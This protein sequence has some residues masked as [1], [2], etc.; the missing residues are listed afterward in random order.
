MNV[1][2]VQL[3]NVY[4]DGITGFKGT[5][6]GKCEYLSGCNQVLLVPKVDKD[7]KRLAGEWFDIQRLVLVP[8]EPVKL[9]NS[10]TP[11]CDMP[12]PQE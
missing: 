3:G 6:T 12:A 7:G 1:Q 2:E 5:A 10:K 11:G 9:D 4:E 8:A